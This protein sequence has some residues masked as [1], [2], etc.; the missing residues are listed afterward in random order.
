VIPKTCD[1]KERL[2]EYRTYTKRRLANATQALLDPDSMLMK[3]TMKIKINLMA[4][5][6]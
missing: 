1:L 3:A 5:S 2:N 6:I 4:K